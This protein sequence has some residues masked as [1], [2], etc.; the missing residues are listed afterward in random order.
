MCIYTVVIVVQQLQLRVIITDYT[1]I[2][3]HCRGGAIVETHGL[4]AFLPGSHMTGG[5]YSFDTVFQIF[6][7]FF[8]IFDHTF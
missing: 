2:L 5:P 8:P 4:R 1:L 6:V 7:C 3:R